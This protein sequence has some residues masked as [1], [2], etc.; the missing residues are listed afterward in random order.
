MSE[1][2]FKKIISDSF[3]YVTDSFLNSI[4]FECKK[5]TKKEYKDEIDKAVSFLNDFYLSQ[6]GDGRLYRFENCSDNGLTG[7]DW[8][9]NENQTVISREINKKIAERAETFYNFMV[10]RKIEE[11]KNIITK[12]V[13]EKL[14]DQKQ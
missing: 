14:L 2:M 4:N 1:Q 11:H 6:I 3:E 8:I 13:K 5:L 7:F 9:K 12:T 10:K